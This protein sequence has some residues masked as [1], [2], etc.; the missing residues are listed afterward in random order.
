MPD[1]NAAELMTMGGDARIVLDPGSG[2]NRYFSAP[3]PSKVLAFASSTAN[4]ISAAAYAHVE[5]VL[6]GIA[7]EFD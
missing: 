4:D 7:R 1:A 2:L 5:G 6:G 3:R